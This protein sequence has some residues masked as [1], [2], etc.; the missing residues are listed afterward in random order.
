[1]RPGNFNALLKTDGKPKRDHNK[2]SLFFQEHPDEDTVL[3]TCWIHTACT[4]FSN[5][6]TV[7]ATNFKNRIV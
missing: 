3:N 5:T 2:K 6:L 1:M 7:S 4:E